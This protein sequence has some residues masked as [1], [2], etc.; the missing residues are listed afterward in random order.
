VSCVTPGCNIII[1]PELI[2]NKFFE[3]SNKTVE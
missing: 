3:K 1:V 2:G